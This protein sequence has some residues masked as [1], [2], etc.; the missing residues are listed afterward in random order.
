MREIS[1]KL[2]G[3]HETNSFHKSFIIEFEHKN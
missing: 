1:K 2:R 3:F